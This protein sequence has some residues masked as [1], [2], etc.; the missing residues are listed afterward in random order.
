MNICVL[1]HPRIRS[2][3]R[4][5]DIANTPLWSCLMG[6][7]AASSL[8]AAGHDVV[9]MD[10]AVSGWGFE[11]TQHEIV[12]QT[13]DMLCVNAVYLWE[14]TGRLFDFLSNLRKEGFRGHI[15][16]FGFY[17]TLAYRAILENVPVV[18]S[19]VV[20]ECENALTNLAQWVCGDAASAR[21]PGIAARTVKG[22]ELMCHSEACR[23]PDDFALPER[24]AASGQSAGILGSRG[25]YNHCVFCPVPS[26]YHQGPMWRGRSPENILEEISSLV[27][28][29]YKDFYFLDPNFIGPGPGGKKRIHKLM[30]M[31]QPLHISFG[32]ETRPNDLDAGLLEMMVS[33][34]LKSLLMGIESGSASVLGGLRKGACP[35]SAATAI[36]LCREAGID[37]EIGFLMFVP[38]STLSDLKANLAFLRENSLL[39]RLERTA[40]LLGHRQIVL[41]GTSGYRMYQEQKRLVP[42]GVFGFEGDVAYRDPRVYWLSRIMIHGC[43]SVLR[44]MEDTDSIIFWRNCRR[45]GKHAAAAD[46]VNQYLVNLFQRLLSIAEKPGLLPDANEMKQVVSME[47][48]DLCSTP[49]ETKPSPLEVKPKKP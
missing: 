34:G 31:M 44:T 28:L 19:I 29:G 15:T 12:S 22:V 14:H 17:P 6:G 8:K 42:T 49:R 10:A 41:M 1:E 18:D 27:D 21:V 3:Q 9:F 16:L 11:Q 20:G 25:C 35:A 39:D 45:P 24:M 23:E 46:K 38:D 37:P 2:E 4:F 47:L 36:R 40:N 33:A 26:F 30:E 13:P 7:Y 43:L 48:N 5:N 32:M